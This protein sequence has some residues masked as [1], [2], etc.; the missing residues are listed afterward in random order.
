VVDPRRDLARQQLVGTGDARQDLGPHVGE[1]GRDAAQVGA[2]RD[3]DADLDRDVLHQP[4]EAVGERQE[5]QHRLAGM[6]QVRDPGDDRRHRPHV[7]VRQDAALGRAGRAGGVDDGR[8]VVGGDGAALPAHR[9]RVAG[10][11]R[12]AACVELVQPDAA[13]VPT[14]HDHQLERAIGA[15][16]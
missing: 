9:V 13:R 3:G 4:R 16:S 6:Q 8:D 2:V 14:V 5:Q 10:E 1:R 7:A 12:G 15:R 11:Q